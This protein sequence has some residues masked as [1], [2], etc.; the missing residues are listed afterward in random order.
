MLRWVQT[1]M[2]RKPLVSTCCIPVV[3]VAVMAVVA[4]VTCYCYRSETSEDG[5]VQVQDKAEV[6]MNWEKAFRART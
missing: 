5:S 3:V 2:P 4:A 6:V 1:R